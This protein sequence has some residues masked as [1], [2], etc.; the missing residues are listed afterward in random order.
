[1]ISVV[2]AAHTAVRGVLRTGDTA[3]DATA[4]NGHDTLFLAETVGRTGRVISIDMSAVALRETKRRLDESGFGNVR[5]VEGDHARLDEVVPQDVVGRV[6]AVM[7]NLG[8]RPSG[9]KSL[10]TLPSSTVAGIRSAFRL[11]QPDSIMTVI[12]YRGHPGG[13]AEV[14]AVAQLLA[15]VGMTVTETVGDPSNPASPILFVVRN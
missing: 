1:M 8:Y 10:V 7:F 9:D 3:I 4:G 6:A 13:R 2:T 14:E 12:G 11:L 15:E 5:L